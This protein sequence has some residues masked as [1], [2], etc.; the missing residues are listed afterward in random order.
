MNK[1]KTSNPVR[2]IAFFLTG[3]LLTCTFGF[4]VDGWQLKDEPINEG[5]GDNFIDNSILTDQA[6]NDEDSVDE[7]P[8]IYIPAFINPLTGL[9]STEEF[10]KNKHLAF[11][12]NSNEACYGISSSDLL[13]EIPIEDGKS[14]FI[15]FMPDVSNLW[16]IGSLASS[17]GYISNLITYFGGVGIFNGLDDA[18]EYPKCNNISSDLD[19]QK[20]SG[21]NYTEFSN[22]T[23]TN[24]DLI[25]AGLASPGIDRTIYTERTLPF[26]FCD[27]G[28]EPIFYDSIAKRISIS[29]EINR[30]SELIF[31]EENG[32]YYYCT[33]NERLYDSLNG[34][35]LSFENCFILFADSVTYDNS[36]CSQ[37]VMD[38][39]G[40]GV[41]YYITE[42]SYTEIQWSAT[43][44]GVMT[45]YG[46]DGKMLT[47]NRGSSYIKF[48]KS[49]KIDNI[50]F[51]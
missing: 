46:L 50:I 41:G 42:G 43:S 38:T 9:E 2:L 35:L 24:C 26:T 12:M 45:F 20:Y 15:S 32:T 22:L 19:M 44:S 8:E 51:L 18:I 34:K 16:K 5:P 33:G 3:I 10:S 25:N 36:S 47:I 30:T 14:R 13:I 6:P 31:D 49:S 28:A 4:T 37:M 48:V 40:S 1:T 7:N 21:Y 17:R 39:I 11:V 27:F 23:Y 29:D